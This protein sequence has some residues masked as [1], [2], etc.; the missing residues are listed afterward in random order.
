MSNVSRLYSERPVSE[1]VNASLNE[2]CE[3]FTLAIQKAKDDG[4]PQGLLVAVLHSLDHEET[5]RLVAMRVE[6]Q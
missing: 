6:M 3:A 4:V 1:Q 2:M 5:A